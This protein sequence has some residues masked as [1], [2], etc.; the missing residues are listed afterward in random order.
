M[1]KS[2]DGSSFYKTEHLEA[3]DYHVKGTVMKAV[4]NL[5]MFNSAQYHKRIF[6]L[7]YGQQYCYFFEKKGQTT[8]NKFHLQADLLSVRAISD[9][10]LSERIEQRESRRT[11]SLLSKKVAKC[12]WNFPFSLK[13]TD[14][15]YELYAPTRNDRDK[16]LK[17]L[18]AIAEMNKNSIDLELM[19]PFEYLQEKRA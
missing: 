15:I 12:S 1:K 8:S 13:F 16:W 9:D 6:S 19:T 14:R 17:I 7:E 18:G 3:T 5:G 10:E 2:I 4:E 11:K